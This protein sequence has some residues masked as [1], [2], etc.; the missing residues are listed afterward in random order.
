MLSTGSGST[1][2]N[3]I[4]ALQDNGRPPDSE[5]TRSCSFYSGRL[6]TS[7]PVKVVIGLISTSALVGI[8]VGIG[9]GKYLANRAINA[10]TR[11]QA[12]SSISNAAGL[13]NFGSLPT[14][15]SFVHMTFFWATEHAT[16]RQQTLTHCRIL[17]LNE[18]TLLLI[19]F[20]LVQCSQQQE[21]Q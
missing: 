6:I 8:G 13:N 11:H 21:R 4:P 9:I 3:S 5:A 7:K 17:R 16:K 1:P 19:L 10:L 12:A 2:A 20:Q 14:P 15:K 18:A